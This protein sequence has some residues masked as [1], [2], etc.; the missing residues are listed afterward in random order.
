MGRDIYRLGLLFS[1]G[2]AGDHP[3][4]RRRLEPIRALELA[5][6]RTGVQATAELD[7]PTPRRHLLQALGKL[8]M[9]TSH[10]SE[11]NYMK[12]IV[13]LN[14]VCPRVH[15]SWGGGHTHACRGQ[16]STPHMLILHLVF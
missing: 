9:L 14:F 5:Y 2:A 8:V 3:R 15:A 10:C 7:L 12:I 6:L 16:R 1:Q 13:N 11:R 4:A